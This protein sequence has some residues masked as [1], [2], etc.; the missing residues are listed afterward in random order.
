MIAVDGKIPIGLWLPLDATGVHLGGHQVAAIK[1]RRSYHSGITFNRE[2]GARRLLL[3]ALDYSVSSGITIHSTNQV[4]FSES[5]GHFFTQTGGPRI[6][7]LAE[8][9][10]INSITPFLAQR[11]SVPKGRSL[12]SFHQSCYRRSFRGLCG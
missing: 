8:L 4:G 12:A 10:K 11:R 7:F 2:Q 1:S 9:V 3:C 6:F 5:Q